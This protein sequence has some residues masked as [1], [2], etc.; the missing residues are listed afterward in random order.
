MSTGEILY[1]AL[2]VFA[3]AAFAVT[4]AAYYSRKLILLPLLHEGN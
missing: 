3:G 2:V 1:L 4:L